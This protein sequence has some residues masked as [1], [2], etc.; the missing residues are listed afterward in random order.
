MIFKPKK[1]TIQNGLD[2]EAKQLRRNVIHTENLK[3]Y[4]VMGDI[5]VR[6]LDGISIDINY[7][8]F[9]AIMGPSGSGKS[10][11]MN[12]LGCLD[13]PSDGIYVL[14]GVQVS[15][16]DDAQLAE[17][18]NRKIGF[19]FQSFNLLPRSSALDNVMLPLLYSSDHAHAKDRA[20]E[21]LEMVGLGN[22]VNHK[23]KELSGGQQQRVAIARAIVN[24]PEI[25]MADEPTGNL[26]SNSG[27]EIMELLIKL[28]IDRGKTIIM[29]THDP[30]LG[31]QIPRVVSVFDGK[32]GTEEEQQGIFNGTWKNSQ[33]DNPFSNTSATLEEVSE[34]R[35]DA[36]AEALKN[37]FQKYDGTKK[38]VPQP[39][40]YFNNELNESS[41]VVQIQNGELRRKP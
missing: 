29:V 36:A 20:R 23:P 35:T 19:V 30:K 25:I 37:A 33:S 9:T 14:D 27:R 13:R 2:P 39:D 41:P 5:E 28:N 26:D 6:A 1:S 22:R 21:A 3:K 11:L 40:I 18:R 17:I 24:D 15:E 31:K 7:G 8:E 34:S 4:Y 16:M 32:L 12:M 10:T 38:D